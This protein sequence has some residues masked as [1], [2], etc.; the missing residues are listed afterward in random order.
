MKTKLVN[1]VSHQIETQLPDFVR[2]DHGLFAQ[3]VEDYFQFLESAKVTLDFT[4]DYVILEPETKQYLLSENGILGAAVDRMV[5]E[6]STEY[7]PGE[8]VKGQTSGAEAKVIVED[9]RNVSLYIGANN[10]FILGEELLGLTSGARAKVVTYKANPVQNIQQMLDYADVDNS[11]FEFFDQIKESF[12]NTIPNSLASNVSKRNLVKSI[13]DLYAAKGTSEGHKVFMR[14]LLDESANIFYPNENMLRVSDGKWANKKLI[15]VSTNGKGSG[16][17]AVNQVITG[18][19]SGATAVVASA[20]TF[21]Q[22]TTSVIELAIEDLSQG[23]PFATGE[24]IKCISNSLDLEI[25]F[26]I[27]SI[28]NNVNLDNAGILHS[29]SEAAVI[30]TD[31]GNGF[32]DVLVNSLKRG[33][34]S[35][36]FIQTAGTGYRLGEKINF[37]SAGGE[38]EA[39]GRITI[40]GGGIE[41]ETATDTTSGLLLKE[42]GSTRT[43]EEFNIQLESNTVL[44]GP[45][46]IFA[47]GE[48]K[49]NGKQQ[50]SGGAKG[51]YYPLFLTAAG[52]GGTT[53]SN[54]FQFVEFPGVTFYM[55]AAERNYAKTSAPTG[56][57]DSADYISYPVLENDKVILDRTDGAGANAG[58][59]IISDETQVTLDTF[60]DDSDQIFLEPGTFDT[61]T[62]SSINKIFLTDNGQGYTALPT[63]SVE[64]ADG[65]GAKILAL[66]KDIGAVES[67]KINDSGFDYDVNDLPD[68]RFRAHFVLK[69]ITGSFVVGDALTSHTGVVKSFNADT[70][71]LDVTLEDIVKIRHEQAVVYNAPFVQEN[72]RG[73]SGNNLLTEDVKDLVGG[74]DDNIILNGTSIITPPTRFI[75]TKVKVVRNDAD[76]ANVFEIDNI[77]QKSLK[78]IEGNTYK[79]DLSDSSLYNDVATS[80]HQ[81]KF[82]TTPDGTHA[83]GLAYTTGVTENDITVAIGTEG[84]YIQ[85][86]I[87]ENA[88]TL[89][90]YCANHSGM[91]GVIETNTAQ[92]FVKDNQEDL[93]LD[94]TSANIF[95]ILAEP[96]NGANPLLAIALEDNSGVFI[97]E[98]SQDGL[99]TDAG[100]KLLINSDIDVSTAFILG[101]DGAR[102]KNED[103]GNLITL[104]ASLD[105]GKILDETD[106]SAADF[107]VLD[108]TNSASKN[109]ADS[110]ILNEK[111]DFLTGGDVTIS[112]ATANGKVLLSDIATGTVNSGVQQITEGSYNNI[113]SLVGEDLIRVQDSYYYQQFSYEVQVGQSVATYINELRKAVHPSG[114]A[115]FGKVA[116]ASFLNLGVQTSGGDTFSPILGSVLTTLFDEKFRRTHTIPLPENRIGNRSDAIL[117]D[118]TAT[119]ATLLDGTDGSSTDAGDNLL[120]ETGSNVL[121]ETEQNAGDNF[122]FESTT[123]DQ[124]GAG[125]KVMAETSLTPSD[126]AQNHFIPT[127][128]LNVQSKATPRAPQNFLRTIADEIFPDSEGIQLEGSELDTLRLDGIEPIPA[129][130]FFVLN[131]SASSGTDAGDNILLE[132]NVSPDTSR[133]IMEDSSFSF[134]ASQVQS[135]GNKMLIEESL[136]T[137]DSIPL[138]EFEGLRIFDI[139][140]QSKI[141]LGQPS[142]LLTENNR[143][144]TNKI[145]EEFD[146]V[147]PLEL[148]D[149]SG[150]F[151]L[152]DGE[153]VDELLSNR[154]LDNGTSDINQAGVDDS[155]GIKLEI[156]GFLKLD[157]HLITSGE[158]TGQVVDS[159]EFIISEKTGSANERFIL[160]EDGVIVAEAFSTN[161]VK[162]GLLMEDATMVPGARMK[163]EKSTQKNFADAFLLEDAAQEV[164]TDALVLDSTDGTADA[165]FKVLSEQDIDDAA[166]LVEN[167]LLESSTIFAEEGQIPH[168]TFELSGGPKKFNKDMP[169]LVI[170]LGSQPIVKS[171]VIEVRSA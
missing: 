155:D 50:L 53:N 2:S 30:D 158:L 71:Q 167:I 79:F 136:K 11:L 60:G 64:T 129:I 108:G 22:G 134:G 102:L 70:Q 45:Y 3:F 171:S 118:G 123:L 16:Q 55:P 26:T 78:L 148:E 81:L 21:Q 113:Q 41:L 72:T 82:S 111:I 28:I 147:S 44:D 105:G 7:T 54:I 68:M 67:L 116:I 109:A 88:P 150:F 127:Y 169:Q 65:S 80:N 163:A 32:A 112:T 104:E 31:K 144:F 62:A 90:Y 61:G 85:I 38:N 27:K 25:S 76:T 99:V 56:Q 106:V 95:K 139:R 97:T 119:S 58:G 69:D 15:R 141:L 86:T 4:T 96:V 166:I 94:G 142:N 140:R 9:V 52:A 73:L 83:S 120:L 100:S 17:E 75:E 13:R 125:G 6:S 12:M 160:E 74:P 5:L 92:S 18:Q 8:T 63:A 117:I 46:Y 10:R 130:S 126:V 87:A 51:Y 23:E 121:N 91:G 157:G 124:F 132:T 133:L 152:E 114:F 115:P 34:V 165:G 137:Y 33:S 103:H 49:V 29:A 57:Y 37:T 43:A 162:E 48:T 19:T 170:T 143:H 135:I 154:G 42:V 35:D 138:S 1:K 47:T 84:A 164:A 24:V 128:N 66:T 151:N 131:A 40:L 98:Q 39:S 156:D 145:I 20:S 110:L 93:L 77:K 153:T 89:Y 14:L 149:N 36:T 168:S 159:D 101:E 107:I 122:L 161:S 146:S 59:R